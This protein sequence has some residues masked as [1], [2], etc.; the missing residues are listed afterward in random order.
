[1]RGDGGEL[2]QFLVR[3]F[4]VGQEAFDLRLDRLALG[5]VQGKTNDADDL[6]F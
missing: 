6:P 5:D 4:Q 3:A 2:L 1:V